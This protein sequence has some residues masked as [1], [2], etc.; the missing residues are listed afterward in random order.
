MSESRRRLDLHSVR[1]AL[2]GCA[3][4]FLAAVLLC[5]AV[6]AAAAPDTTKRIFVLPPL[7]WDADGQ[8]WTYAT[9]QNPIELARV[10]HGLTFGMTPEDVSRH[11][12][13]VGP[14]PHWDELPRADEFSDD[15]RYIWLP[16]TGAAGFRKTVTSC[17]GSTSYIVLLFLNNVLFRTSFR[18]L[19]GADCPDPGPAAR[20]LYG[21]FVP[22]APTL[23]VTL[24]YRTGNA[25]VVD[26]NDPASG[27]LIATHWQMQS[28]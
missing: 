4:A 12:G 22:L 7:R 19:P 28:Q 18:F 23:A 6:G 21:A 20:Q 1:S 8:A 15:V 5:P 14:A 16:L 13:S 3:V 27:P 24:L 2:A 17:F 10:M 26:V 11:L 9:E 25:V